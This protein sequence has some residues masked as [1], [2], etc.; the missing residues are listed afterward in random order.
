MAS[1]DPSRPI[2]E[3]Q[4]HEKIRVW[5]FLNNFPNKFPGSTWKGCF[6]ENEN[7]DIPYGEFDQFLRKNKATLIS[8]EK[9]SPL[10]I[11]FFEVT[12]RQ[13]HS[14]LTQALVDTGVSVE[15]FKQQKRKVEQLFEAKDEM[16]MGPERSAIFDEA[17][18][19]TVKLNI[20][21]MRAYLLLLE[22]GYNRKDLVC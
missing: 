1:I 14:D 5:Q 18:N 8:S 4:E 22:R 10:S 9:E 19:A 2:H 20:Q 6:V 13:F 11:K 16:P 3:W 12:P 17:I 15:E 21:I 7:S